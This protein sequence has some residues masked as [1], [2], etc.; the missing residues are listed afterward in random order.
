MANDYTQV[1]QALLPIGVA[2]N[3]LPTT[4]LGYLLDGMAQEFGRVEDRAWDLI[5][6]ADP[7][8][9]DEL[10]DDWERI[11]GLPE[12]WYTP[13]TDDERR[14][15]LHIKLSTRGSQTEEFYLQQAEYAGFEG[16]EIE[17]H[18][19]SVF[20]AG[21]LCG[22]SINGTEW[23]F[24]WRVFVGR[25]PDDYLVGLFRNWTQLHTAIEFVWPDI[26]VWD[27]K[28]PDGGFS[29][30]FF[31]SIYSDELDLWL[32]CGASG[33][34]QISD[35]SEEWH[36]IS[37]A[38]GYSNTF[39]SAVF[40]DDKF[41]IV[42]QLAEIQTSPDGLVWTQRTPAGGFSSN[43]YGI[44][45]A[46]GF[47]VAVGISAEIQT[48]N[49]GITWAQQT[50]GSGF[51]GHFYGI[52]YANGLWVAVGTNGEIQTSPDAITWTRRT[53]G[54]DDYEAVAW[55]GSV[56]VAAGD[57]TVARSVDGLSWSTASL[58]ASYL[59]GLYAN[60]AYF[61]LVGWSGEI[62]T[63]LD[64]ITWTPQTPDNPGTIDDFLTVCYGNS[65]FVL[66]GYSIYNLQVCDVVED[67]NA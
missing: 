64:G 54:T 16:I 2:W 53:I 7:R 22:E 36:N 21:S 29:S 56:F 13:S 41:V 10:L 57:T 17:R 27:S 51:T 45:F 28:T 40:G 1:M 47:F 26:T 42:G 33:E 49:D 35:D 50:A 8:T 38:G 58:T 60:N 65:R 24:V 52:T 4:I 23:R 55:N 15:A 25:P 39:F 20:V 66:A 11:A 12:S 43:F 6:E 30:G 34:I 37:P 67:L 61:V 3:R 9:T 44:H 18:P 48:S 59:D 19:Y 46:Q 63:S 31:G 5:E 62:F 32:I 14:V